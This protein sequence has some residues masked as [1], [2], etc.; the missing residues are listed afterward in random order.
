MVEYE[1][2]CSLAVILAIAGGALLG[3]THLCCIAIARAFKSE[4]T[5]YEFDG[6]KGQLYRDGLGI[7]CIACLPQALIASLPWIYPS[8][9]AVPRVV[10]EPAV[11]AGVT[12]LILWIWAAIK[13]TRA[14][15]LDVEERNKRLSVYVRLIPLAISLSAPIGLAIGRFH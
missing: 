2:L 1:A 6:R 10:A 11:I 14:G 15:W 4:I 12:M 3:L 9:G 7:L 5:P 8:P 13:F